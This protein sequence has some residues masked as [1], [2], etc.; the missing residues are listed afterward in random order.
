[1][2][3]RERILDK[4]KKMYAHSKSAEAIGSEAEA[5]AFAAKI[6]ELLS[7][8]KIELSEVEY[9]KLDETDPVV[10]R[11]VK[12]DSVGIPIKRKRVDW[13][14]FMARFVCSAYFCKVLVVTG[15]S[16]L[17]FAGRGTDIDAAEQVF[18][19]L[20]RVAGRLADAAYVKYFYEAKAAGNVEMARGFRASYLNGFTLRLAE[21]Y[22]EERER[23]RRQHADGGT[24]LV[25]LTDAL[26]AVDS[27]LDKLRKAGAT[28]R[29]RSV[30]NSSR[31]ENDEGYRRGRKEASELPIGDQKKQV[32]A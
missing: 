15:S 4:L 6:Q 5:Q 2:S 27:Y 29:A 26:K 11:Y 31:E 1:M 9:Q 8:H 21:R 24:A 13:H 32:R 14:E 12:W 17:I 28:A 3:D 16:H 20:V 23:I 22:E 18:L 10:R 7:Q 25:R 19:Y 30:G